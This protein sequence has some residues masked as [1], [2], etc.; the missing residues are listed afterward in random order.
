MGGERK[1]A[2]IEEPTIQSIVN[3]HVFF[4]QTAWVGIL[5]LLLSSVKRNKQAR[6][7]S[8]KTALLTASLKWGN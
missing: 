4:S 3:E 7:I 8:S 5:N 6:L 1:E 2:H